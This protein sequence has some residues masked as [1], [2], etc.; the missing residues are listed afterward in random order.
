[1]KKIDDYVS[2]ILTSDL[3]DD[4]K[5]VSVKGIEKLSDLKELNL[6]YNELNELEK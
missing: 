4:E 2:I 6:S 1:M 5:I 3:S